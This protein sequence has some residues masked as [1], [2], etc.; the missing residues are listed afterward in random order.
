M[1]KKPV[2]AVDR[3]NTVDCGED[4]FGSID[5]QPPKEDIIEG[6]KW[7]PTDCE[8]MTTVDRLAIDYYSR[9]YYDHLLF[10]IKAFINDNRS[11]LA[12]LKALTKI[13][14]D[15]FDEK[16]REEVKGLVEVDLVDKEYRLSSILEANY[17]LVE[18]K[19]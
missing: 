4:G 13:I 18:D 19:D 2:N 7:A 16:E 12:V 8:V 1:E 11:K 5:V 9:K 14:T 15:N 6:L 17:K 10:I 3:L